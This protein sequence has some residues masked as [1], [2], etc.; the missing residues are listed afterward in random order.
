MHTDKGDIIVELYNE[1][2]K[3]RDNFLRLMKDGA[4]NGKPFYRV[5]KNFVAQYGIEGDSATLDAEIT[6]PVH[7][8]WRGVLAAAR[9]GDEVNPTYRSSATNFYFVWGR[10]E[11]DSMPSLDKTYTVFG[12]IASGLDVLEEIMA[13]PEGAPAVLINKLTN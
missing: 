9:R 4:L 1:T 12:E 5:V 10:N 8:H 7:L 2:P 6:Y 13:Q 11:W 3:H